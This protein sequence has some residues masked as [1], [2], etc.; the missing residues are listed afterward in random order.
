ME[1][2]GTAKAALYG[3]VRG[4]ARSAGPAG[5]LVNLVLPGFVATAR[6]RATIPAPVFEQMAAATPIRRLAT[7]EDIARLAVFL[8][9]EA[10]GA[11]TG[12]A[13]RAGGGLEF[14]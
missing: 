13:V 7:E 11:V 4:L 9:S 2:Y 14:Q 12:R 1:A 3:L 10:N 6:H 8:A 5:V